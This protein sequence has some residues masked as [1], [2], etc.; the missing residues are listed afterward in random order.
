MPFDENGVHRHERDWTLAKFRTWGDA[1]NPVHHSDE[2]AASECGKKMVLDRRGPGRPT[3]AM[4]SG[5]TLHSEFEVMIE[6][7]NAGAP[8]SPDEIVALVC[9]TYVPPDGL[10][11]ADLRDLKQERCPACDG[12]GGDGPDPRLLA[13]AHQVQ[14]HG[15]Y[16][17]AACEAEIPSDE[18]L[19]RTGEIKVLKVDSAE[20]L[21]GHWAPG[22]EFHDVSDRMPVPQGA[23]CELCA[24]RGW[25][26]PERTKKH[27]V[28]HA[29]EA[30]PYRITLKRDAA[31]ELAYRQW[32]AAVQLAGAQRELLAL[33]EW[34]GLE[35][36]YAEVPVRWVWAERGKRQQHRQTRVDWVGRLPNGGW[37]LWDWK[38][39]GSQRPH[40]GL[41]PLNAQLSK[42]AIAWAEGEAFIDGKW[43]RI[44]AYPAYLGIVWTPAYIPYATQAGD[45][46]LTVDPPQREGAFWAAPI[47]RAHAEVRHSESAD[48]VRQARAGHLPVVS[49]SDF[50]LHCK[51]CAHREVCAETTLR[52]LLPTAAQERAQREREA[53]MRE[54]YA[55]AAA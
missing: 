40:T 43:R 9:A 11:F 34:C 33:R 50:D 25:L 30:I 20:P 52:D 13:R 38:T 3:I 27:Q 21:L 51:S 26:S 8:L 17:C 12:R 7:V 46:W 1:D 5:T 47:P 55:D 28:K 44:G 36:M 54:L 10:R 2:Q 18:V 32:L 35:L 24:G 23:R 31:E 53:R 15:N 49:P 42:M 6:R 48:V 19:D 16:W 41:L 14:M 22:A 29:G 4:W 39:G 37:V 45:G